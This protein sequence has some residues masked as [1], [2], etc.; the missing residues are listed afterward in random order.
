MLA[1]TGSE[2]AQEARD[3]GFTDT[4]RKFE[5]DTLL[6]SLEQCLAQPIAA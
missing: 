1:L 5:R 2:V 4:I 6:S 3:A